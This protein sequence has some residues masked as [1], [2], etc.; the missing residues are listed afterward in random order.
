MSEIQSSQQSK[1]VK[2]LIEFTYV[3]YLCLSETDI[4]VTD[5]V[6]LM[7]KSMHRDLLILSTIVPYWHV[8]IN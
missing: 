7:T 4:L 8:V 3:L 1:F 5:A 2:Q 6:H